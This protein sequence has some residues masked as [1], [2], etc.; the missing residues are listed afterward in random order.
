M[1]PGAVNQ[2]FS[3]VNKSSGKVVSITLVEFI[4][5]VSRAVGKQ[6]IDDFDRDLIGKLD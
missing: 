6:G 4:G 5:G 1:I 3:L 2:S